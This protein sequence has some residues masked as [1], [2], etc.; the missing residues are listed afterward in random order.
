MSR[1]CR[2]SKSKGPFPKLSNPVSPDGTFFGAV[3]TRLFYLTTDDPNCYFSNVEGI[4]RIEKIALIDDE[5]ILLAQA[6]VAN[7]L[8][9]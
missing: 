1:I 5:I 3:R 4:Y 7:T 6:G 9:G 8:Q 2:K